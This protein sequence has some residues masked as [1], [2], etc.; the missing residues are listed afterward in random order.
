[1]SR[2]VIDIL[3]AGSASVLSALFIA[4]WIATTG[5]T[6]V[7]YIPKAEFEALPAEVHSNLHRLGIAV[8]SNN[9]IVGIALSRRQWDL[10]LL[11]CQQTASGT[12]TLVGASTLPAL[13]QNPQAPKT[14]AARAGK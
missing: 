11:H 14:M 4:R 6:S 5:G 7:T 13:G 3:A 1:M 10:L 8:S 9:P 2:L 12:Q